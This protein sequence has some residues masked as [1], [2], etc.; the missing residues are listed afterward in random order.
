MDESK[1]SVSNVGGKCLDLSMSKDGA[2]LALAKKVAADPHILQTVLLPDLHIKGAMEAPSS[3]VAAC[4]GV[5]IPH[6]ISSAVND[7]MGLISTN[8]DAKDVTT[9]QLE[10]LCVAINREAA[11]T[12]FSTTKYSWSAEQLDKAIR[13]GAEPLAKDY[14]L[15]ESFLD[16]IEDRGRATPEPLKPEDV[17][18]CVPKFLL[19]SKFT[20]SEIGI[21]FG[22]NHFLEIQAVD[23]IV[24]EENARKLGLKEG[25]LVVMYHLGPG[26]LGG[27][28]LNL[29][30]YRRK[31]SLHRKLGYAMFRYIFQASRGK[32]FRKTFGGLNKW[33]VVEEDS[34]QGK[35][36]ATAFHITKNYGFA[37]RM[38]TVR[39][40][41]DAVGGV[42]GI[43]DRAMRL[44]VDISHN[45]F[46][47][48]NFDGERVWVSRHNACRPIE[49][50]PGII[51]GSNN[52]PSCITIGPNGCEERIGGYDHGI[53]ILL[54]K[55]ADRLT[56]DPR[57]L[58][59]IRFEVPRGAD[60]AITRK[61]Y[62]LMKANVLEKVVDK[63]SG[64]D[65]TR[66]VA[67][68][69]PLA[70]LKDPK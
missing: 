40:I 26:P 62:S 44:V 23:R 7:G 59:A 24:D 4:K 35:A 53:G 11:R 50:F 17:A 18:Q 28:L 36:L 56:E 55:S 47:P 64:A 10:A 61:P 30:A 51:S 38:G 65:F 69:R 34:P 3:F 70:T 48:E 57:S 32:A 39:A 42:L 19:K 16:A 20:R 68:V 52:I 9:E 25:K 54:D 27:N 22:G 45:I 14:G 2:A 66:P 31:P 63:L 5:I 41:M 43:E 6:L 8:I 12:K 33:L 21:N 49:G 67:Y 58:Q 1:T 15:D 46:Q 37:Y 29:Y 60:H 13:Y